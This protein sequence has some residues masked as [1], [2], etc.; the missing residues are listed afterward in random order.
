M[1]W[2]DLA[3]G[4]YEALQ[5]DTLTMRDLS[6]RF[7]SEDIRD[8]AA[9]VRYMVKCGFVRGREDPEKPTLYVAVM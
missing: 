6:T 1:D 8:V 2:I 7:P 3:D 9:L 5:D 4:I